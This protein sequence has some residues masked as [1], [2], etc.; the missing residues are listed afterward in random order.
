MLVCIK[1]IAKMI[2]LVKIEFP[3][4]PHRSSGMLGCLLRRRVSSSVFAES[5]KFLEKESAA[6]S[7]KVASLN[8][9]N[10]Q[11]SSALEAAVDQFNVN[12]LL[13][14][15]SEAQLRKYAIPRL[16]QMSNDQWIRASGPKLVSTL[17]SL[18]TN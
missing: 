14:I 1:K 3:G 7:P 18:N 6:L 4:Q 12:R 2:F 5:I 16:H 8:H 17:N 10:Q 15:E 13:A 11:E 9:P